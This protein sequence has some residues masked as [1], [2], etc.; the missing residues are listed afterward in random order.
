MQL[1]IKYSVESKKEF[2]EYSKT[3]CA[4]MQCKHNELQPTLQ[5]FYRQ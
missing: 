4:D 5:S 2:A 1:A 3:V